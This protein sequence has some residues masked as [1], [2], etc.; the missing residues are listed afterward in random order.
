MCIRD[1]LYIYYNHKP[2][3]KLDVTTREFLKFILSKEGQ[4]IVEKD[5]YFSLNAAGANKF[6]SQ[7]K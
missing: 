6:L 7:L 4:E 1:R 5:G 2:G 3:T